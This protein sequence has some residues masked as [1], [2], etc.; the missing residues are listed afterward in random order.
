[1]V[2]DQVSVQASLL[3]AISDRYPKKFL[4]TYS[5]FPGN[6]SEVVVQPYN[7]IL[8]LRRLAENSDATV[9]FDNNALLNLTGK[10]FRDPKTDY[11]HTNQL[12]AATMSS[13]T[14]SIRFPSYMFSSIPSIFSTLVPSPDLHFLM[15]SFTPFTSDYVSRG[16]TY[17]QNN[18]YDVLLDLLD[19]S[20]WLVSTKRENPTYFNVFNTVIGDVDPND[21]TRAMTKIQQRVNFAP[22]AS[23]MVHVNMGRRSPYLESNSTTNKKCIN[24]MMLANSTSIV[25]VMDRACK[26]FDKIFSKRAFLRTF[27]D[28]NLFQNGQEEFID[29]REVVQNVI[30]DYLAAE[31]DTY[32][33]EVLIADENMFGEYTTATN[34]VDAEGD[35]NMI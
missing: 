34:Q 25:S 28:G 26:T 20:N 13:I 11:D 21:I 16:N 23:K 32:L 18:A 19:S 2:Q 3:E 29:S 22:W 17:K 33:D 14:N 35:N 12:I 7:T 6:E 10:V 31:E 9:V 5:V 8:T 4:S 27:E 24:G 30:D 15:P 1:M